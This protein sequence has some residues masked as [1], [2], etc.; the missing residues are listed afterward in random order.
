[1]VGGSFWI[2]HHMRWV[3]ITAFGV[4]VEPEVKRNFA[5]VSGPTMACAASSAAETGRS[6]ASKITSTS[7]GTTASI[8]LR[9]AAR[10]DANTSPGVISSKIDRSLPKSP[11]ASEYVGATGV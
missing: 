3:L 4:P 8:A 2:E 6:F 1:I 11:D 7:R 5:I 10:S 9:K